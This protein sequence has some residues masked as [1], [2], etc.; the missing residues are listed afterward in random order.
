[1]FCFVCS[2][3]G[4]YFRPDVSPI[5]HF[6]TQ[7]HVC[8]KISWHVS[9]TSTS[10]AVHGHAL[11][12]IWK[13]WRFVFGVSEVPGCQKYPWALSTRQ[14]SGPQCYMGFFTS[15]P[16]VSKYTMGTFH[17]DDQLRANI[18]LC[19]L[20]CWQMNETISSHL[21]LSRLSFVIG[22]CLCPQSVGFSSAPMILINKW[23]N[24]EQTLWD[25][26]TITETWCT[27]IDYLFSVFLWWK[28]FCGNG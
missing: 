18:L 1:M 7:S 16:F 15:T 24:V 21:T 27:T 11:W 6:P 10:L 4:R 17:T 22:F 26:F 9:E 3:R 12:I 14:S 19:H 25:D 13:C 28:S 8:C 23:E 20:S 2:T 5:N